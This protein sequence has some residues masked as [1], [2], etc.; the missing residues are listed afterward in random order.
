MALTGTAL[1][2]LMDALMK[3]ASIAI[4]AYNAMLW[5]ALIG[6]VLMGIIYAM[7]CKQ[8][9]TALAMRFHM[10]RSVTATVMTVFF[11]WGLARTPLA[12]GVALSFIAPLIG[13]YLARILL[14]EQL[15]SRVI[16][17]TLMGLAGVVV[18]L[19]GKLRGDYAVESLLGAAAILFSAVCYAYNL[20][21]QRQQTAHSDPLEVSTFQN[22][23]MAVLLSLGAPWFAVLPGWDQL[24]NLAIAAGLAS[25]SLVLLSWAYGR[26]ETQYLLPIEYS[27]FLWAVLF[28]A[29]FFDERVAILTWIGAFLILGACWITAR[30][31]RPSHPVPVE[32]A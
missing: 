13:L 16:G 5:R 20:I 31:G 11:F 18:I 19:L 15:N 9:P 4:G 22:V 24:P 32:T 26:A 10:I 21:L 1:F 27:A 17:A 6:A 23:F 30:A 29:L 25:V 3:G 2:A 12:E 28:G 7:R 14:G 8:R